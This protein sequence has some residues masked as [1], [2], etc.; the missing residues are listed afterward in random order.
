MV[1][2]A[3]GGGDIPHDL[4]E[5]GGHMV[6]RAVGEHH[7]VFIQT[8]GIDTGS[9]A[10]HGQLFGRK[11]HRRASRRS[12]GTLPQ[13]PGKASSFT[14]VA[15]RRRCDPSFNWLMKHGTPKGPRVQAGVRWRLVSSGG[16]SWLRLSARRKMNHTSRVNMDTANRM[17]LAM[18]LI[19]GFT[20]RRTA[21]KISIGRVV[22]PGP[23]TKLASTRSSSDRVKDSSQPAT[24]EGAIMGTVISR[25][26]FHGGAPRS[27]A[28]SSMD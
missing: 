23:E 2:L 4:L 15:G 20:P 19:S 25:K 13:R 9:Q 17:T 1:D 12:Y 5:F 6:Q 26:V 22:E 10:G 11:G 16:G 27:I 3:Q 21:E 7:R 28:A 24:I 8:F 18:A 14:G